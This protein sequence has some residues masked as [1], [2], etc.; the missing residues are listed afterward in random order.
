MRLCYIHVSWT[1]KEFSATLTK[2]SLD[3]KC[4][5]YSITFFQPLHLA[6][7]EKKKKLMEMVIYKCPDRNTSRCT[8]NLQCCVTSI[9]YNFMGFNFL[10]NIGNIVDNILNLVISW[11]SLADDGKTISDVYGTSSIIMLY[12]NYLFHELILFHC[13]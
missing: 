13:L 2:V 1:K 12:N 5:K 6:Q 4:K 11:A 8:D 3:T 7:I 9:S 10:I